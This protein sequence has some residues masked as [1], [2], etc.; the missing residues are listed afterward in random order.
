[1]GFIKNQTENKCYICHPASKSG[2]L[3]SN[4]TAIDNN[5]FIYILKSKKKMSV[6][7]LPLEGDNI[8]GTTVI[9]EGVNGT[10]KRPLYTQVQA[11]KVN[12]GLHVKS[13]GRFALQGT[14]NDCINHLE[15]C[16][17][18]LSITLWLKPSNLA[19]VH[20]K[21]KVTHCGRSINIII[22]GNNRIRTWAWGRAKEIPPIASHSKVF[23]NTWIHIVVVYDPDVGLSVY[24]NG[25]L[26]AIR[27]ISKQF[28]H[29]G[30][31]DQYTFGSRAD[32]WY[33]FD[34]TL[35]EIKI[36]YDSLTSAGEFKPER[37]Y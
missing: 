24:M 21:R 11:G 15:K 33:P 6:M 31:F 28:T 2:I 3:A 14:V 27:S 22:D 35:D 30:Y 23:L 20:Y 29:Y 37:Y 34:G 8:T 5:H 4:Y 32:G 36:F 10:L 12:Q 16:T 19:S 17:N 7:Y 26:E 13:A 25:I 18:G 1:M 9:G